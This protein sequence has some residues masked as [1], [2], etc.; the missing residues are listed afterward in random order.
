MVENNVS[1]TATIPIW[2]Q[3]QA[4]LTPIQGEAQNEVA[5]ELLQILWEEVG[6]NKNHPLG[7]MMRL[8]IERIQA[9]EDQ[10]YPSQSNDPVDQLDYLMN[11][12]G[13][14]QSQLAQE[15]GIDQT[16]ISRVLKRERSLNIEHVKILSDFFKKDPAL[17]I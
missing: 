15:T 3:W 7:D 5:L 16:T 17:F 9:F 12:R 6:E 13:L 10:A 11:L 4:A 2:E 14:S 8:I 1:L